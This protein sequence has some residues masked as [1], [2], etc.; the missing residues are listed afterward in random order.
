LGVMTNW[1]LTMPLI[2]ATMREIERNRGGEMKII[3]LQGKAHSVF[4]KFNQICHENGNVTLSE[5]NRITMPEQVKAAK[6]IGKREPCDY[7]RN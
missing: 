2:R 1:V 4:V 7:G 5:Y 6:V 3:S